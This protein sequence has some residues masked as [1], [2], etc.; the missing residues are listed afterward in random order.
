MLCWTGSS[1]FNSELLFTAISIL[2]LG[3]GNTLTPIEL[4]GKTVHVVVFHT[5]WG[6]CGVGLFQMTAVMRQEVL[7]L[8]RK[9]FR[10]AKKWQSASGQAEETTAERE[11]IIKEAKTLFRKNK[12]VMDPKLIKQC[13]D[14]CEARIQIGLHY[15]IP[16]PRPIHLPPM[17]LT[18]KQGRTF[19]HQEK[20]RKISKPIYL[21]SHDEIS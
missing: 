19:R 14:E 11:Y 7:G 6:F 16:Y 9:I 17:G 1:G 2:S 20:L 15:N 12:D 18:Q 4:C 13:I 21:K 10:I 5:H 3:G 8:Y